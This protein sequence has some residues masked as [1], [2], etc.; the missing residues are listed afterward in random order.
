MCSRSRSLS[1]PSSF[2][3]FSLHF[4]AKGG[5]AHNWCAR[6]A[7]GSAWGCHSSR[8]RLI[9]NERAAPRA[10]VPVARKSAGQFLLRP[11]RFWLPLCS[12]APREL[13]RREFGKKQLPPTG[14]CSTGLL[15]NL[16]PLPAPNSP[17]PGSAR[18]RFGRRQIETSN[19]LP[20]ARQLFARRGNA[21]VCSA[22]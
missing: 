11:S 9:P 13:V 19:G 12:L 20:G 21:L 1:P 3:S 18:R 7:F 5:R 14:N 15:F 4:A 17:L 6:L 22:R 2:S 8:G 16:Q 10:S